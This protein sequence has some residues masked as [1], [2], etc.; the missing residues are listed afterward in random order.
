MA[1]DTGTGEVFVANAAENPLASLVPPVV[2]II[3]AAERQVVATVPMSAGPTDAVAYDSGAGEIFVSN[4]ETNAVSVI[5]DGTTNCG[6]PV[7]SHPL[8]QVI[9]V[10]DVGVDPL[11]LAYDKSTGEVFVANSMSNT[12]SVICDGVGICGANNRFMVVATVGVGNGPVDVAWDSLDGRVF[13]TN[14]GLNTGPGSNTVS[15]ICDG[16]V[17]ACGRAY[18]VLSP[19][20]VG[21]DPAG[22]AYD[23]TLD[24]VFVANFD[25]GN[26]SVINCSSDLVKTSIDLGVIYSPYAVAYDTVLK[27]VFVANALPGDMSVISTASDAVVGGPT[28]LGS[29]PEGITYDAVLGEV[30]VANLGS[31]NVSVVSDTGPTVVAS[32]DVGALP[33][34][35]AFDSGW[36]GGSGAVFVSDYLNDTVSAIDPTTGIIEPS[37]TIAVGAVPDALAYDGATG[38]LFVANLDSYNVSVISDASRSVVATIN[39]G[40]GADPTGLAYDSATGEIFVSNHGFNDVS[41]I[42]DGTTSA[43][44]GADQLVPTSVSGLDGPEG[45]VYDAPM[46]EVWAA[47]LGSGQVSAICDGSVACAWPASDKDT[48]VATVPVGALPLGMAYVPSGTSGGDV[49]V[50]NAGSNSVSVVSDVTDTAVPII[51]GIGD[52]PWGVDYDPTAGEVFVANSASDTVSVISATSEAVTSVLNVGAGP[53]LVA[54]NGANVYVTNHWQGT[55]S[56]L[57]TGASASPEFDE[58]GIPPKQLAKFGWTIALGRAVQHSTGPIIIFP[59]VAAGSYAVLITGPAGYRANRSGNLSVTGG[60]PL[61]VSFKKGPTSTVAFHESGLPKGQRWCVTVAVEAQ[62]TTNV[63]DRYV[64]LPPGNYSYAVLSPTHGQQITARV[65]KVLLP[66]PG[67]LNLS[68]SQTVGLRFVYPYSLS[69]NETGLSSGT[70]SITLAG[71]TKSSLAGVPIVFDLSNGTY[72]YRI[73]PEPGYSSSGFPPKATILGAPASVVVTFKQK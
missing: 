15:V 70:W 30:F 41:V 63:T 36:G 59:H 40:L 21:D 23:P 62:C 34:G 39:L 54:D 9:Q 44:V 35:V 51:A 72:R 27:E 10:I 66:M 17:P 50:S 12:V 69:F 57:S 67:E 71:T 33:F 11:G 2:S 13:V 28:D 31:N 64:G 49:Y 3:S 52:Y 55:V 73:A 56:V 14:S 20:A 1:L 58:S 61:A 32:I 4:Y 7:G 42:C 16:S 47:D 22:I 25:I 19:V 6:Q 65:G 68:K 29:L 53:T 5:C 48:V 37:S 38:Q 8:D 46:G 60:L 45:L 26:V 43:C 18:S 24:E